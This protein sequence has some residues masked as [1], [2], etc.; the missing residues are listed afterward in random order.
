MLL[1][2][3]FLVA[4]M[5]IF[6]SLA[7]IAVE[8]AQGAPPSSTVSQTNLSPTNVE[9]PDWPETERRLIAIYE[10]V[11]PAVVQVE[12]TDGKARSRSAGVIVTNQGHVLTTKFRANHALTFR[13]ADG[14]TVMGTPLG[15]SR[16]YGVAVTKLDGPGPW[17][18]VKLVEPSPERANQPMMT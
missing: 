14:R 2:S 3:R 17:P 12:S 4:M 5:A 7:F 10:R 8:S 16:E 6:T 15:W 9:T 11:S 13:L 1:R 18:F